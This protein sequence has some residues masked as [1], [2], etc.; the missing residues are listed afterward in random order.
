MDLKGN[1]LGGRGLGSCGSRYGQVLAWAV[2]NV[3]VNP[4]VPESARNLSSCGTVGFPKEEFAALMLV[5]YLNS[6]GDE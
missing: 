6:V 2:V 3:A 5:I 4:R 1:W